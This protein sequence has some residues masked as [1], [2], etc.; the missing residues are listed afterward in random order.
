MKELSAAVPE[1]LR[2]SSA[3]SVSGLWAPGRQFGLEPL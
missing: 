1:A 2:L 3:V